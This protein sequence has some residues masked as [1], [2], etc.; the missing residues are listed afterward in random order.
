MTQKKKWKITSIFL[1]DNSISTGIKK[2]E[3][4]D[5]NLSNMEF[6]NVIDQTLVIMKSRKIFIM[7]GLDFLYC[8]LIY[9]Q[10]MV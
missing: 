7:F 8:V 3:K 2:K 6:G 9:H 1:L 4:D 5:L 10:G